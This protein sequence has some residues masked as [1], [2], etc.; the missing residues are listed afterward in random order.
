MKNIFISVIFCFAF[1]VNG[2]G[3]TQFNFQTALADG[4]GG[5]PAN[6]ALFSHLSSPLS[7]SSLFLVYY[8]PDAVRGFNNVNPYSPL[9]GDEYIG[10]Y[11][12]GV[13][14]GEI[15]GNTS[16][17]IGTPGS[18]GYAGYVYVAVFEISYSGGAAP[19]ISG[20]AYYGLG[21]TMASTDF[22]QYFDDNGFVPTPSNYG[23]GRL[24]TTPVTTSLTVVPEPST[25]GLLLV[26]AGL[27][28]FRRM[29]RS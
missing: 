23:T 19:A 15:A 3:Y 27:V 26:G 7:A 20:G 8:S 18:Y 12:T 2:F 29:R 6:D 11:S 13:Y 28:A 9:G 24:E 17:T 21:N 22:Q 4:V 16:V 1:A 14:P 5:L 10:S 25:I